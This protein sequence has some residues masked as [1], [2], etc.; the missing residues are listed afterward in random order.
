[1]YGGGYFGGGFYGG[2][3]FG[4]GLYGGCYYGGMYGGFYYGGDYYEEPTYY[5]GGE[6]YYEEGSEGAGPAEAGAEDEAKAALLAGLQDKIPTKAITTTEVFTVSD[7]SLFRDEKDAYKPG[8]RWMENLLENYKSP[9]ALEVH[10]AVFV[11][12]LRT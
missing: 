11:V 12:P 9:S 1:M 4:G 2:G 8:E 3:D 10:V 6:Y 5:E 7:V